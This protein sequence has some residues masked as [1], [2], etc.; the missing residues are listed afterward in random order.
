MN[1]TFIHNDGDAVQSQGQL[2]HTELSLNPNRHTPAL[3]ED[4]IS[5]FQ[6]KKN[7]ILTQYV[8]N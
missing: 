5:P 1:T 8:K 4:I 2:Y 6:K 3:H 7:D